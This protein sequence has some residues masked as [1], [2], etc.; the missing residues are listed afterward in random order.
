MNVRISNLG[1]SRNIY[2]FTLLLILNFRKSR[3]S[4]NNQKNFCF[5]DEKSALEITTSLFVLSK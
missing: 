4:Q 1:Q 5:E 3:K 2:Y